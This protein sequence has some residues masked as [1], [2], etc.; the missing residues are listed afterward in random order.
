MV[1]PNDNSLAAATVFNSGV[2]T[3][4]SVTFQNTSLSTVDDILRVKKKRRRK[5]G[6]GGKK[7]EKAFNSFSTALQTV[8]YT[9]VFIPI[10]TSRQSR[11]MFG[12]YLLPGSLHLHS[13]VLFSRPLK[14]N[15]KV[16]GSTACKQ[17]P[18]FFFSGFPFI[19]NSAKLNHCYPFPS[20][21]FST[22]YT[23]P[24]SPPSVPLSF[25]LHH[26]LARPFFYTTK[27][28]R[29]ASPGVLMVERDVNLQ[30]ALS[31]TK[32]P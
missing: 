16:H 10:Q 2:P 7:R 4:S 11:R 26:S 30:A 20:S 27:M 17:S 22:P 13:V 15:I 24:H 19:F 5:M 23:P 21:S 18:I 9:G 28:L 29:A 8:P 32:Q 31:F 14:S 6:G 25:Y 3:F 12:K 1:V